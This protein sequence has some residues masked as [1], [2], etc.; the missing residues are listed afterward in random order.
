MNKEKKLSLRLGLLAGIIS[1]GMLGSTAGTLAWY[2]YS[3]SVTVSYVGTTVASSSLLNVGLVDNGEYFSDEDLVNFDLQLEEIT[4]GENTTNRIVWS[5]ARSGFSLDALRHYLGKSPYAVDKLSPVTTKARAYDA[6]TNLSLFRS[7]E[8]GETDFSGAA[9]TNSYVVLPFAFRV[10]NEN[11]EYVDGKNVWLTDAT[12]ETNHDAESSIRIFVDNGNS[13]FLMQPSDK[14]DL[15]GSTKV[16][17]LLDL[18]G[19]GIYDR[20]TSTNKEFCYGEFENT[21][22]YA[23]TGY[24]GPNTLVNVN[25][26]EDEVT[27]TTF[28]AKHYPGVLVPNIQ[29]AIPK[30]Q[31]HA[32]VGKVKPSVDASGQ[33]Y[34]DPDNGNGLPVATTSEGSRIGYST[35]TIFAEGWDHSIIDQNVNYSFNL[36]LKFE[37]DRIS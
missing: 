11:S 5:R 13:K 30:V 7:P 27:G 21:P 31:T 3:R 36:G 33:F 22:Q 17:G 37:I 14:T 24:S 25:G 18:V 10:I 19:D 26:V 15:I 2:A 1:L 32:G 8:F 12:I 16:G 6:S 4:E 29:A 28:L 35:L 23:E 9:E 34:V 20:D